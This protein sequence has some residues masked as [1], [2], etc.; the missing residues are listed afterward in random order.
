MKPFITL[1]LLQISSTS[2]P[3]DV[4]DSIIPELTKSYCLVSNI[5]NIVEKNQV[6]TYSGF[7]KLAMDFNFEEYSLILNQGN[8]LYYK[9]K[10]ISKNDIVFFSRLTLE[11]KR[12]LLIKEKFLKIDSLRAADY[13]QL[14]NQKYKCHLLIEDLSIENCGIYGSGCGYMPLTPE[15]MDST[16]RTVIKEDRHKLI[17]LATS[18]SANDRAYGVTGLYL[19]KRKGAILSEYETFLITAN[20]MSESDVVNCTGCRYGYE[21]LNELIKDTN[22]ENV[23]KSFEIILQWK[24]KE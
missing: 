17:R 3:Q 24:K 11:H 4:L 13:L 22:L 18:I 23:Y 21:K 12:P 2:F 5:K 9:L 1:I 6:A 16:I 19:L 15:S 7:E 10:L 8:G 14:H 20:Q